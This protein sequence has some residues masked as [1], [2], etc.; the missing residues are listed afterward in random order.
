MIRWAHWLSTGLV[1]CLVSLGS[2]S[3]IAYESPVKGRSALLSIKKDIGQY[4]TIDGDNAP[5]NSE[6]IDQE[7]VG[8]WPVLLTMFHTHTGEVLAVD[9]TEPNLERFSDFLA[10]R[11]TGASIE[12]APRLLELVRNIGS[13]KKGAR[14]EVV[15]GYRSAKLNE[16][17]RKK[18][19]HVAS[20]SQHS[21]GH[22]LDFR[23]VGWAPK[24]LKERIEQ[25]GWKGGIGT[26]ES[27]TDRFVHADVGPDRR[28]KGK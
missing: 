20:H 12:M 18:G 2:V 4:K 23:I 26:Y 8:P 21:L 16:M 25:L 15:S 9:K 13:E 6:E 5:K 17:L 11:A 1:S 10:D 14:L 24:E 19:H 28:W 27:P 3:T 7:N 22:A